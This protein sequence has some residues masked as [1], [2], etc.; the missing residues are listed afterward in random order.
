[1]CVCSSQF[2]DQ[3]LSLK[4]LIK[5]DS[6]LKGWTAHWIRNAQSEKCLWLQGGG[7][8]SLSC[9]HSCCPSCLLIARSC[10]IWLEE[11]RERKRKEE[12]LY[13]APGSAVQAWNLS[14]QHTFNMRET[15]LNQ[16]GGDAALCSCWIIRDWKHAWGGLVAWLDLGFPWQVLD[17]CTGCGRWVWCCGAGNR[18]TPPWSW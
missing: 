1:M 16:R 7:E 3:T 15:C 8:T 2:K 6:P 13:H 10:W 14:F 11:E 4:G 17:W 5:R 9:F 18:I 12:F